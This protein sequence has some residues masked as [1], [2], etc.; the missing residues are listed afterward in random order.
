MLESWCTHVGL[1][2][3]CC[4]VLVLGFVQSRAVRLASNSEQT[5]D[6]PNVT[7]SGYLS[8]SDDGK[9]ALF[10]AYYEALEP[11]ETDDVPILLWLEVRPMPL[12]CVWCLARIHIP[13]PFF[14][15]IAVTI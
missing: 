2:S 15:N 5:V 1:A 7:Y 8:I 9:D 3:L 13:S 6:L 4:V 11:A 12:R 14:T 10:Y